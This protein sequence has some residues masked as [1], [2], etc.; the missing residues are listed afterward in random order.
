[1][2]LKPLGSNM[3]L[4]RMNNGT[5]V[6]FSYSTPVAGYYRGE[7][8]NAIL[9]HEYFRTDEWYSGTTTRHINKYLD[10]V[11]AVTI[12]QEEINSIVS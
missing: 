4:I 10:G 3:T 7:A 9:D 6:L 5:E 2:K 12:E 11:K 8:T 1:M